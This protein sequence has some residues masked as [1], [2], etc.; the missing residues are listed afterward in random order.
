[1]ADITFSNV[2]G[3]SVV[4][5]A[6]AGERA[7]LVPVDRQGVSR[8]HIRRRAVR[9]DPARRDHPVADRRRLAG[10]CEIRRGISLWRT[11]E[12]QQGDFRR[13][14]ADLR[15]VDDLAD[16]HDHRRPG[17]PRHCD[18]PHRT[19]PD[20]ASPAD[21][22]RHRIARG[23][24]LDHLRNLGL[25]H[26][27]AVFRPDAADRFADSGD[28]GAAL[29]HRDFPRRF[30]DRPAGFERG[31]VRH[32]LHDLGSR[33]ER[34]RALHAGRRG[35][36]RD[37]GPWPRARRDDGGDLRHRQFAHDRRVAVVAGDDDFGDHRQRISGI[38]RRLPLRAAG[39]RPA[40]VR[41]HLHRSGDRAD[42]C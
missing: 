14:L 8:P 41:H 27:D 35:R 2:D 29:H 15:H 32:R 5:P 31:G 3:K 28:H 11:L 21:R 1:M 42:S 37:A 38:G 25:F 13:A 30:H 23:H 7:R 40:S 22:H 36:R 4:G 20:G 10:H 39:A 26:A 12:R 6:A 16:R 33:A 18:L 19:L 9:A 17:R 24:S 34:R